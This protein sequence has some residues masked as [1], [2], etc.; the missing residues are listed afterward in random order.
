MTSPYRPLSRGI[1]LLVI[2]GV[3]TVSGC[4]RLTGDCLD[5]RMSATQSPDGAWEAE[6][7][8]RDYGATTAVASHVRLRRRGTDTDASSVA[9]AEPFGL[10]RIEWP[11]LGISK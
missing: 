2:L 10:L 3:L 4:F 7:V 5:R 1:A 8:E 11:D 9:T 6:L